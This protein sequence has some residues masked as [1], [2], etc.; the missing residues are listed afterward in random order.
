MSS[1]ARGSCFW[2]PA[3]IEILVLR[4]GK[5]FK[6]NDDGVFVAAFMLTGETGGFREFYALVRYNA[7]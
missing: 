7:L 3:E 2:F 5:V 6:S 1:L 4:K